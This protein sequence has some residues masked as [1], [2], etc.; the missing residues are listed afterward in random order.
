MTNDTPHVETCPVEIQGQRVG[1]DSLTWSIFDRL[2]EGTPEVLW[3]WCSRCSLG[4]R[5]RLY[6][7]VGVDRHGKLCRSAPS[8]AKIA[9]KGLRQLALTAGER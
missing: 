4:Q 5:Q 6:Y 1:K 7:L 9:P 8:L 3:G 2:P